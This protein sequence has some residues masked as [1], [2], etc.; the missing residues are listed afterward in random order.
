[1][2]TRAGLRTSALV[3][4]FLRH[5]RTCFLVRQE[6]MFSCTRW[7]YGH[8]AGVSGGV[9]G[10]PGRLKLIYVCVSGGVRGCAA[11]VDLFFQKYE[12]SGFLEENAEL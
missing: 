10:C 4:H 7:Q 5:K 8:R 11:K 3:T 1:M 2:T 6:D 9:R 12:F